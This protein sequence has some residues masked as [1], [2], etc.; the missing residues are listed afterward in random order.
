MPCLNPSQAYFRA[1]PDGKKEIKFSNVLG[2]MFREGMKMPE[3]S[4]SVPCGQ[5]MT[6]RLERSRVTALR[7]VHEARM[8]SDSC[9]ITLT[10]SDESLKAHCPL[11]DGGYTLVREHVQLFMK[12]LRDRFSRGVS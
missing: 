11:T 4:M 10:Y 5:C 8:V 2:R 1:R 6:C 7:C 9:F 12:R 3:D